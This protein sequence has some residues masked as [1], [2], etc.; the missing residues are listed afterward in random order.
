MCDSHPPAGSLIS[1]HRCSLLAW[2][3]SRI[4]AHNPLR[5]A[6]PRLPWDQKPRYDLEKNAATYPHTQAYSKSVQ[7]RALNLL[8]HL[9]SVWEEPDEQQL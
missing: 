8:W 9:P 6:F 4:N 5:F 3:D 2:H 1:Y 7:E